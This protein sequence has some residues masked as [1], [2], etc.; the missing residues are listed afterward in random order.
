MNIAKIF[1]PPEI[2]QQIS[3]KSCH[4]TVWNGWIEKIATDEATALAKRRQLAI[5]NSLSIR[6]QN[7]IGQRE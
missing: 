5:I 3:L 2:E 7:P 6:K 1:H 4:R